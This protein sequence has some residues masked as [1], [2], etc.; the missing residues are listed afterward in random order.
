M[1]EVAISTDKVFFGSYVKYRNVS[2]IY[3]HTTKSGRLCCILK[4]TLMNFIHVKFVL[5]YKDKDMPNQNLNNFFLHRFLF[6]TSKSKS[7]TKELLDGSQKNGTQGMEEILGLCSGKFSGLEAMSK[8]QSK[9]P[10]SFFGDKTNAK[11]KSP[12]M[13]ELLG[14]CSG[15]FVSDKPTD[16]ISTRKLKP[17]SLLGTAIQGEPSKSSQMDE[18]LGLCS[19]VFPASEKPDTQ[20]KSN[21]DTSPKSKNKDPEDAEDKE[22]Y[23]EKKESDSSDKEEEEEGKD[24]DVKEENEENSDN[25]ENDDSEKDEASAGEDSDVDM[26]ELRKKKKYQRSYGK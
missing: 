4:G 22:V 6:S 20:N 10:R 11:D 2:S 15:Q 9:T 14:L 25:E 16:E 21:S 18:L 8:K 1:F 23:E 24:T 12:N 17:R 5:C 19:G 7:K 26:E 3:L 13:E